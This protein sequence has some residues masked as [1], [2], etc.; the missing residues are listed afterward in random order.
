M[1]K[2]T[3]TTEGVEKLLNLLNPKKAIG[4]DKIPTSIIK[5]NADILAPLI[6]KIF[7][8]SI[9]CGEVPLDWTKANVTAL[10]K[11]GDRSDPAN[12]RP[13]SLMCVLCNVME[14]IIYHNI[15]DHL[16]Y[17]KI[18]NQFQHG[19]RKQYSCETQLINTVESI[20]T[21]TTPTTPMHPT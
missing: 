12:Y 3:I 7:Q 2:L 14:H 19:F 13:V 20:A 6:T 9:D 15:M 11:K 18:L 8:Q 1:N 5:D 17:H 4:P 16:E 21:E 10:F